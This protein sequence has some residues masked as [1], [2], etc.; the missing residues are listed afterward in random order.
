MLSFDDYDKR[1]EGWRV[2][3]VKGIRLTPLLGYN[4]YFN[5][6]VWEMHLHDHTFVSK[7]QIL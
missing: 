5:V 1:S 7:Q 3:A 4:M 6:T 2:E